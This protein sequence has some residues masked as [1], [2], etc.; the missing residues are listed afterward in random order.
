LF[1]EPLPSTRN[2]KSLERPVLGTPYY[3]APEVLK[4]DY[5]E[6]CDL[7][8]VGAITY[9]MLTGYPPFNGATDEEI[10]ARVRIGAYSINNLEYVRVSEEAIQF[11]LKLLEFDP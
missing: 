5:D 6:R 8:S 10:V 9:L 2:N 1:N 4:Q 7:W 11:I 3:I